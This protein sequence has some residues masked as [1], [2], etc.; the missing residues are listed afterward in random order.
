MGIKSNI[1]ASSCLIFAG[2]AACAY[3]PDDFLRPIDESAQQSFEAAPPAPPIPEGEALYQMLYADEFGEEARALGQRARMLAWLNQSDLDADQL[4]GLVTLAASVRASVQADEAS[5]R[6]L[7]PQELESYRSTYE[8]LINAFSGRGSLS[9]DDLKR[10]AADLRQAR[11]QLW[12]DTNPHQERYQRLAS[13]LADVQ[14]WVNSLSDDQKH[15]LANV[16]FFLR[17]QLS[18]L[19][20]P[21]HYEAMLAG[22]WDIGDFDTLRYAGRSP[23]EAA[24]DIG[25]LW[26]AEAYRVRPGTHLTALQV[27]ALMARALME[28]G[29]VEAIEVV[30]GKRDPLSFD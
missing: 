10:H 22:S 20:R 5:R 6:A 7:G 29:L 23:N 25:G 11:I 3:H 14:G 15:N 27:Q 24:L 16:R 8:A 2:L 18:P 30:L 12:G 19:S 28:P 1:W 21:G 4:R 26:A 13:V 17:R 9:A